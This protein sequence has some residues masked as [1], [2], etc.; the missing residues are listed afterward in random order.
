MTIVQMHLFIHAYFIILVN[1]LTF[2]KALIK[3]QFCFNR[4]YSIVTEINGLVSTCIFEIQ[5]M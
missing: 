5:Y 1:A 4:L 3:C 2:S